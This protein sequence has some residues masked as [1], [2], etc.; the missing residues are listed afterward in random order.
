MRSR[1][2]PTVRAKS[3]SSASKERLGD[4]VRQVSHG[5]AADRLHE[6]RDVEPLI[7]V[8]AESDGALPDGPPDP[9]LHRLEAEPVLVR[10]PDRSGHARVDGGVLRASMGRPSSPGRKIG[11]EHEGEGRWRSP[12]VAVLGIDLGKNSCSVA[13]L[14]EAGQIVLRRRLTRD[15]VVRLAAGMPTYVM[16]MEACCGAR[17]LGRVLRQQGHEVRLMSP[18]YVQPY[19]KVQKNNERDA[20]ASPK[21]RRGRRCAL[22]T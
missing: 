5:F 21:L 16:A 18:E 11:R 14:D 15:G 17:H 9:A 8:M 10:R 4:A 20:E 1:P 2:A 13:G 12:I 3:A 22:S 6:R 7:T 19:V